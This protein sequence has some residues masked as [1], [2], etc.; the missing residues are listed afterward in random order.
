[1]QILKLDITHRA[2]YPWQY[3]EGR[4]CTLRLRTAESINRISVWYGDPFWFSGL[5]KKPV[6]ERLD[7]QQTQKIL[8]DVLYSAV[9]PMRTHKLHYYFEIF[10]ANGD[11]VFLSETGV[12]WPIDD[13][14][15]LRYFNVPYVHSQECASA[16]AWAKGFVWY[17]IFSDR[18]CDEQDNKKSSDFVP[19]R[20]NFFGGTLDGI[21]SKVPYLRELGVQGVYL[22]P[23]FGS[24]SN[25]R[26]DTTSYDYIEP[27]LGNESSFKKL[28]DVLHKSDMKIMLDGVYNHCGWNNV[29][30][31]DVKR[32]GKKSR[33]FDWF[34]VY[35]EDSLQKAKLCELTSE[36]MRHDPPYESFAF[37]ANM[38]K[39]NT[40]NE[41]VIDYLISR[42]E[43]WTKEY[44]IDA[45]RLDVPDEV[46]MQFLREFS[47]RM[48]ALKPEIYIIGEI[49]QDA[50]PWLKER[51]FHGVMDY[52]LYYAVRDYAMLQKDTLD[53]FSARIQNWF[54]SIPEDVHSRQWAFCSN[55][56]IPR[57]FSLCGGKKED[58]QLAYLL[59]ALL[60][61]GISIY[62]G[63]E[64]AMEGGEDP[65][66]RRAMQWDN[67]QPDVLEFFQKLLSLKK[68]YLKSARLVEL[69][70]RE[71]L[72]LRLESPK[73]DIIAMITDEGHSVR[74]PFQ[75]SYALLLDA[76]NGQGVDGTVERFAV[77]CKKKTEER[78]DT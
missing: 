66:N 53:T 18:F 45:W 25:H 49:W 52:P 8:G 6:L 70:V 29:F 1:M 15:E 69:R 75:A 61:G 63:D 41:D 2:A 28:V 55:H 7:M 64:T 3:V 43:R 32:L 19:T 62:Y 74:V 11:R 30:W 14:R 50:S 31:Q 58:Y 57:A 12:T 17:Q 44:D 77:F 67:L 39:W 59:V 4:G 65:D 51:V 42:A 24:E 35:D 27:S 46:S 78:N 23:I 71:Y 34:L 54:E 40:E 36:R 73:Y 26:Y 33:Y 16:P 13:S 47:K 9:I 37:A 20:E 68:T 22:N 60:G 5:D 21:T 38:P 56:D 76:K 10:L 48:R 72:Y